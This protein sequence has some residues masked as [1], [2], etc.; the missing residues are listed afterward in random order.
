MPVTAGI[1][2]DVT[3]ND[4]VPTDPDGDEPPSTPEL[5]TFDIDK[6][7]NETVKQTA[8][9]KDGDGVGYAV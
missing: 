9:K 3:V 1:A 8:G 7:M 4:A 6:S 5:L 2:V